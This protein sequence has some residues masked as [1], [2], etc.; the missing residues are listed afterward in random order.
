VSG[1]LAPEMVWDAALTLVGQPAALGTRVRVRSSDGRSGRLRLDR[2]AGA[3]GAA[4]EAVLARAGGP[5]LDVGCGPGRHVA[6]LAARGVPALGIDISRAAI[7][8]TRARGAAALRRSVFA[9][10]PGEGAWRTVLVMDGNV[11]IGGDPERLLRRV[12]ALLAPGGRTLVELGGA[13]VGTET[14]RLRLE[15][16][17]MVSHWFPWGRLGAD[18]IE[19][20]AAA[21]GLTAHD[22]FC[23]E[24][25]WFACLV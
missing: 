4:D 20:V 21:A 18:G 10:L 14:A 12:A 22:V 1:V 3:A 9:P 7:A 23:A 15:V 17:G 6:T 16:A 19:A 11:G 13:G 5:V 25:R 2:Y 8:L 24:G